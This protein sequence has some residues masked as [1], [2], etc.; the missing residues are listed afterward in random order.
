MREEREG[1]RERERE[2]ERKHHHPPHPP[3]HQLIAHD[4]EVYDIAWGGVAVF[5]SASADG[6]VRVFDL[7]D[8]DHSTIVYEHATPSTPLLRLAWNKQDPRYMAVTAADSPAVAVLD[9]RFP[10]APV[11]ELARHNGAAN[12]LAWAPHSSCHMCTAGDDAQALIW[13]LSALGS[14]SGG[15]GS[16]GSGGGSGGASGSLDPILAY[17]AGAPVVG[18]EWSAAAPDWVAVAFGSRCQVLRV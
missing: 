4:R 11:A 13:D 3:L 17:S 7:R 14:R 10:A 18:L 1:G 15:G 12:A 2:R 6:S 5:A 9:I 16:G 8:R